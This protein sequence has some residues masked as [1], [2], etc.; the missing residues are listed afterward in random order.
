VTTRQIPAPAP[1]VWRLITDTQAW[2]RWGPSVRAVDAPNRF[3]R[4]GHAGRVQTAIG[5]WLPFRI[6]ADDWEPGRFWH[7]TVAGVPATGHR[8]TAR[9]PDACELTFIVP[10]WAPFYR[11]V[12]AAALRRIATLAAAEAPP[13]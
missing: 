2:P 9:G 13:G 7:W 5:L 12:C 1:I 10:A 3:I 8:V 4:P 6:T 11:P